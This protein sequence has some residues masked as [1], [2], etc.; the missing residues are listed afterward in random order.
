MW[1]LT[2]RSPVSEPREYRLKPGVTRVGR[3][4]CS[5]VVV[6]DNMVSRTHAEIQVDT[7]GKRVAITD[8]GSTNGTFI[9]HHPLPA[10]KP[11]VLQ[12]DDAIRIGFHELRLAQPEETAPLST[13]GESIAIS[14]AMVLES[15][16]RH[17]I[18]LYEII[19]RLNK[20]F[21]IESALREIAALMQRSLGVEKCG[22]FLPHQFKDF[23]GLRFPTTFAMR[24]IQKREAI[25]I[26]MLA[27]D[28]SEDI[29]QSAANLQIRSLVCVPAI[30]NDQ[31]YALIYLYNTS[32]KGRLL[33]KNDLYV[34]VAVAHLAALTIERVRMVDKLKDQEKVHQLLRRFLPP[35]NAHTMLDGYLKTGKLPELSEQTAT[36]LFADIADSTHLAETLGPKRFG[37]ILNR[38][39]QDLTNIVFSYGGLIDKYLGD[40]VMA[41]FG[42]SGDDAQMEKR[43]VQAGLHILERLEKSYTEDGSALKVGVAVN[44]GPVMAGYVVTM[45]RVELSVLGDTV[46]V[47]SRLEALAR[48]NR[49][50]V[51]PVTYQAIQG[52]FR[53]KSIGPMEI[54]GRSMPVEVHEIIRLQT[55]QTLKT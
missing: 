43:A 30:S 12:P 2:V 31:V 7:D 55:T 18:L 54:R 22:I 50:L 40:G 38:Y 17:A 10:S 4:P 19:D 20:V 52:H 9:N 24:A 44:T 25:F 14:Q 3:D 48:P 5:E 37:D 23:A 36:I 6:S 46:N 45:E 47:A 42:I 39:Y 21:D 35:M 53:T 33:D 27:V 28:S 15:L 34:A 1:I 16:D 8:L 32:P 26:P 29:S 41:V 13:V 49:L 51:G 11:Y